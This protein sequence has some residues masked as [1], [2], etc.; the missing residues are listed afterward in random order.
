MLRRRHQRG[1]TLIELIIS[2]VVIGIAAAAILG[3]YTTIVRASADPMIRAQAVAIAEAYMDEIMARPFSGST[4]DGSCGSREDWDHIGAYNNL[5]CPPQNVFGD[6]LPGLGN[7]TVNVNVYN[8]G[9]LGLG[10]DERRIDVQVSDN[11][12][13]VSFTLS[14]WRTAP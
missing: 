13:T 12:N 11:A 9:S 10:A 5:D 1:V 8:D 2:I 7:Y 6:T 3:V 14:A 4:G